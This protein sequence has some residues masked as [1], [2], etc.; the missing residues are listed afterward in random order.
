MVPDPSGA[1]NAGPDNPRLSQRYEFL[2]SKEERLRSVGFILPRWGYSLWRSLILSRTGCAATGNPQSL[3]NLVTSWVANPIFT[4]THIY[5][6][7][8]CHVFACFYRS[9]SKRFSRNCEWGG[10]D[11]IRMVYDITP[12]K[13]WLYDLY[14]YI[15][16]LWHLIVSSIGV[17]VSTPLLGRRMSPSPLRLR[18]LSPGG[19]RKPC[20]ESLRG[21]WQVPVGAIRS[22]EAL[23][24][25]I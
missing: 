13:N 24:S 22:S 12:F 4:H 25:R 19:L 20:G 11:H 7:I 17:R 8:A 2:T 18:Q 10:T 6:Y 9:P 21:Y 23:L 14:A 15:D 3:P 1:S 5:I 16:T